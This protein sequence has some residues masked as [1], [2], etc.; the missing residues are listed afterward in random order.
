M[1]RDKF[2]PFKA[3]PILRIDK[4]SERTRMTKTTR[5]GLFVMLILQEHS[6]LQDTPRHGE[7]ISID[8]SISKLECLVVDTWIISPTDLL[9]RPE[10]EDQ[11]RPSTLITR[12]EPSDAK[13]IIT[14]PLIS[15]TPGATLM[16]LTAP[17]TNSSDSNKV[18]SSTINT[19]KSLMPILRMLKANTLLQPP[20]IT[21]F[22]KNGESSIRTKVLR[23]LPKE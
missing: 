16:E 19:E 18:N 6:Q 23:K 17:G 4:L 13:V 5:N 10:T 21:R 7:C 15:E 3:R 8:H 12:L 22:N 11:P 20:R 2:L 1:R 14:M 9:S